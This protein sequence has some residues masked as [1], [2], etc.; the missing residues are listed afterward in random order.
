MADEIKLDYGDGSP[1]DLEKIMSEMDNALSEDALDPDLSKRDP[2][3]RVLVNTKEVIKDKLS[4]NEI[5]KIT[6]KAVKNTLPEGVRNHVEN[7]EE[8]LNEVSGPI[9]KAV[10]GIRRQTSNVIGGLADLLPDDNPVSNGL[11][12]IAKWI[13]PESESDYTPVE[14]EDTKIANMVK[15][16]IGEERSKDELLEQQKALLD[17]YNS[18]TQQKLLSLTAAE[19]RQ[20]NE[21]NNEVM[22]KYLRKSLELEYKQTIYLVKLYELL[23]TDLA[24]KG[25]QLESI[26]FNTALPEYVKTK[27]SEA[28]KQIVRDNLLE[29]GVEY[30]NKSPF[31]K[32]FTR[33]IKNSVRDLLGGVAEKLDLASTT[34]DAIKMGREAGVDSTRMAIDMIISG[35]MAKGMEKVT[36]SINKRIFSMGKAEELGK[37]AELYG[38]NYEFMLEDTI[39]GL[40]KSDNYLKSRLAD[41]LEFIKEDIGGNKISALKLNKEAPDENAIMDNK[42]KRSIT[43][44]IPTLLSKI[45]SEVR[46]IRTGKK[47]V[48]KGEELVYDYY[49]NKFTTKSKLKKEMLRATFETNKQLANIFSD[50]KI[51]DLFDR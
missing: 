51:L 2:V 43:T 16:I 4:S 33:H 23:K 22:S 24:T 46:A 39:E 37:K 36:S 26:V 1:D 30:F 18:L 25:K 41:I 31:I 11:K 32:R 7:A 34:V 10:N 14:D 9:A 40:R 48:D 42:V 12:K 47:E 15:D 27:T 38:D 5:L 3:E 49:K 13:K 28:L 8:I 21:F 20:L 29:S 6:G 35:L 45:L 19:L 17:Q 50:G 44:V